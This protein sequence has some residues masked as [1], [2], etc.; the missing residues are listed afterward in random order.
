MVNVYRRRIMVTD[1]EETG[2]GW[3]WR[4]IKE[5]QRGLYDILFLF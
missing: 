1:G 5:T 4:N 3:D 2:K